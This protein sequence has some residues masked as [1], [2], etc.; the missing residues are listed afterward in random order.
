AA[1]EAEV[2]RLR[3]EN[4]EASDAFREAPTEEGREALRHGAAS[5]ASARDRV[6]ALKVA[7]ALFEKHAS[8][9][10]LLAADGRVIGCIAVAIPAGTTQDARR[11]L[12][13]D[14]LSEALAD[15][16]RELGVV[17]AA[18]PERYT[19]ERPGRD[20]EGR[21]VLDVLGRVEADRLVP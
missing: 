7:V 14:A 18:S 11:Q 15:A 19:R 2:A 1:A 8:P 4:A 10:G 17:L 12:V 20:A 3:R 9:Y 5:L 21:T 6:E 13:D 16:C